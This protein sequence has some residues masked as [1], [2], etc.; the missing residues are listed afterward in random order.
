M[1]MPQTRARYKILR[2][3][4]QMYGCEEPAPDQPILCDVTLLGADGTRRVLPYPDEALRAA[5]L[6]EGD[7]VTVRDGQLYKDESKVFPL[8]QGF[9]LQQG[10]FAYVF[11]VLIV[12]STKPPPY[13]IFYT[14]SARGRADLRSR[15]W[16]R[17]CS[18][19]RPAHA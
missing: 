17:G 19:R 12:G 15:V 18:Y 10:D 13:L 5:N 8:L 4:G 6:N 1:T 16:R 2:M 14:A 7:G 3:D 9:V 11:G